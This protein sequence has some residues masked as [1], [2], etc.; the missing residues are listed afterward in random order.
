[1]EAR[2]VPASQQ[3]VDKRGRKGRV[4]EHGAQLKSRGDPVHPCELWKT[5]WRIFTAELAGKLSEREVLLKVGLEEIGTMYSIR[6]LKLS[7]FLFIF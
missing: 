6:S 1:L 2:S 5:L 3:P 4:K 7:D